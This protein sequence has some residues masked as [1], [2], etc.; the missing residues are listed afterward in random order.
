MHGVGDVLDEVRVV[1]DDE[2]GEPL[3]GE[4]RQDPGEGVGLDGVQTRA[5][6]VQ[7]ERV[8]GSGEGA[9]EFD[10]A[11]RPGGQTGGG[12]VADGS[13]TRACVEAFVDSPEPYTARGLL[14]PVRFERLPE[15][16]K[17]RHTCLS[18]A[19]WQDG[20]GWVTQGD[21]DTNWATVPQLGYRP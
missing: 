18:V 3:R 14:L 9:G 20:R 4:S 16:P 2:D 11:Q 12:P 13:L 21:M 6:L 1:F 15:P 5:G 8:G 10:P 7:E 17:T 19:R